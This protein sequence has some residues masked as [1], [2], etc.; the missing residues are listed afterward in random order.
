M[1]KDSHFIFLESVNTEEILKKT[2]VKVV[3]IVNFLK[4]KELS[5]GRGHECKVW[6]TDISI[7]W[8]H[9]IFKV[10]NNN[11]IWIEDK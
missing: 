9:G 4:E 11:E 7:S 2:W 5:I 1:P 6:I 10:I 8:L 3:H